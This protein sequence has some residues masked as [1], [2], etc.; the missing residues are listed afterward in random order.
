MATR[1][2]PIGTYLMGVPVDVLLTWTPPAQAAQIIEEEKFVMMLKMPHV[3]L[4]E[5]VEVE[6]TTTHPHLLAPGELTPGVP[7]SE[8]A[9]RRLALAAALPEGAIAVFPSAPPAYMGHDVP[10]P[11]HRL[12][13]S[14][15]VRSE[16]AA[17]LM[18]RFFQKRRDE[19]RYGEERET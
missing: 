9:A 7:A 15:G 2:T 3:D 18:R 17:L 16:E 11:Y 10:H 5:L 8:Y 13:V 4:K 1:E 6:N 12:R 14:G 19:P